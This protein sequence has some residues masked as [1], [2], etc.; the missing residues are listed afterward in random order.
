MNSASSPVTDKC[1]NLDSQRQNIY[2]CYKKELSDII[3]NQGAEQATALLK[4]Q[5]S[6]VAY[7]KSNC[8]QLMHIAGRQTYAKY[9]N[10]AEAF[11]HGDQYCW[12]GYY[13]GIME[14][15]SKEKGYDYV[16]NNANNICQPIAKLYGQQSFNDYNCVHGLGHGFM[17][18]EDE[19]LFDA[20]S[21]CDKTNGSWNQTSCYGGVFMQNIM[22]VQGPEAQDLATYPYLKSNDPMYPCTAVDEKYKSACYL[23]QTSFALQLDSYDFSKVFEQ[24][25]AVDEQY[26][27]ICY[28]SLGRDAS[29]Q[30]ISDVD[31]TKATCLLGSDQAAQANCII[32]AVKDFVSYFHSDQKGYQ[33]CQAMSADIASKCSNTVKSYYSNF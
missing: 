1:S 16:I 8:H 32:G 13:H 5:Y 12:S 17:E 19:N 30:S 4:H 3:K 26:V 25:A 22:N 14:E 21:S 31:K 18:I 33:L 24:C 28:Q 27:N 6:S 15:I 11:A 2:S 20:L 23:M 29:G 9:N 7:V 10:L